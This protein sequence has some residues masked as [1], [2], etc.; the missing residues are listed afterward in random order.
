[1]IQ[2][3]GCI[4]KGEDAKQATEIMQNQ[5]SIM[6]SQEACVSASISKGAIMTPKGPSSY[7]LVLTSQCW[8]KPLLRLVYEKLQRELHPGCVVIDYR[9]DLE[10]YHFL[11][12]ES[13]EGLVSWNAHQT[14]YLFRK[15]VKAVTPLPHFQK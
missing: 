1:M 15:E 14:F 13:H 9:K 11:L 6:K 10:Q 7:D 2:V 8:D 5:A 12:I 3:I 4:P